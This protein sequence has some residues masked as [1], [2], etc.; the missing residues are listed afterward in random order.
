MADL[1]EIAERLWNGEGSTDVGGHHPVT[2]DLGLAE[3]ADRTA[4]SA[5]FGNICAFATDDGLLLVDTGNQVMAAGNHERI[6]GLERRA[7]RHRRLHPR[8]HRPRLRHGALRG[9]GAGERLGAAA[10]RRPRARAAALRALRAHRWVQRR[11]QPAAVPVRPPVLAHRLP[12]PRR[13]VPRPPHPRRW[14]ARPGSSTTTRARPTTPPGCGTPAARCSAPATS[15]SG[16]A[17]TAATR[18]RCSAT[19]ASGRSA[20]ARWPTSVPRCCCPVTASRSSAPTASEQACTDAA[21]LLESP[22]RADAG[23]D[24]RG[25]PPRRHRRHGQGPRPPAREALPAAG[26]RRARVRRPQPVAP[27]RRLVRRQPRPPQ[28]ADRRRHRRRDGVP[29]RRG[30]EARRAG[31]RAG[32]R[33]ATSAWPVTSPS[34]PRRPRPTTP[35]CTRCAPRSSAAAPPRSAARCPRAS[36]AGPSARA[37]RRPAARAASDVRSRAGCRGRTRSG[38]WAPPSPPG[39]RGR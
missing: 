22:R 20:S 30:D 13:G 36:S 18:R 34:W 15:S 9:G 10:R 12:P 17:P 11:D 28:A 24:E 35:A 2:Q 27:L 32:R 31:V 14:A 4:F 19:R 16:P 6:R 33:P 7:P 39:D 5:S 8:A 21:E 37:R 3:V 23:P 1:L 29:R 25:R 26:V 38:P